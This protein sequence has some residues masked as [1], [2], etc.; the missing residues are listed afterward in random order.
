M[1][2]K[3]LRRGKDKFYPEGSYREHIAALAAYRAQ[4]A[5]V[6]VLIKCAFDPRTRLGPFAGPDYMMPPAGM[7]S[8]AAAFREAGFRR[9]RAA[10]GLWNPNLRPSRAR[11]AGRPI[12]VLALSAMQIHSHELYR[13]I[14][15]AHRLGDERPLIIAGGAKVI[16][17]PYH[18]FGLKRAGG[19]FVHP[20]EGHL[21]DLLSAD[22]AVHGREYEMVVVL[23]RLREQQRP[24]ESLRASFRRLAQDGALD[25]IPGLMFVRQTDNERGG[26]LVDTGRPRVMPTLDEMAHDPLLGLGCLERPH[27]RET[28]DARA[29]S[30]KEVGRHA[31]VV[32][33]EMTH[34]CPENCFY[35]PIP[36]EVHNTYRVK[37]PAK[38]VEEIRRV[39]EHTSVRVFFETS[40]NIGA[41]RHYLQELTAAL[42]AEMFQGKPLGD[43]IFIGTESTIKGLHKNLDLVPDLRRAG[44]RG[45]WFGIEDL[46]E[47]LVEKGQGPAATEAVFTALYDHGIAANPMFI[48]HAGQ[49]WSVKGRKLPLAL[50]ALAWLYDRKIEPTIDTSGELRFGLAETGE[51]MDRNH[52]TSRQFTYITPSIGTEGYDLDF[53]QGRVIERVGAQPVDDYLFDGNHTVQGS[54]EED[55][56][57]KQLEL[58]AAYWHAYRPGK[59]VALTAR[60]LAH[61]VDGRPRE[62]DWMD[63]LYGL[64]GMKG[65][66]ITS[67][68][69][70]GWAAR[71]A[72]LTPTYEAQ[73]PGPHLPT[74]GLQDPSELYARKSGLPPALAALLIPVQE[75]AAAPEWEREPVPGAVR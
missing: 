28:L 71:L 19:R 23:R 53:I 29:L 49:P 5:E 54:P 2:E 7:R 58:A 41:L 64:Y 61:R 48:H 14:E 34:G 10:F 40:D 60:L 67:K 55:L 20:T 1:A 70:Y 73:K 4:N 56:F 9:T 8:V 27:K 39:V 16:Y 72:R 66:A 3:L 37:S 45:I 31:T 24:G 46:N 57:V 62:R 65:Y 38:V 51:F 35:C 18:V 42:K 32:S 44:F 69:A 13:D 17:E 26:A 25:D 63:L 21:D 33:I 30:L 22:L 15:D 50:R 68:N 74:V 11:I 12:E 75:R 6:P 52:A 36:E 47:K 59:V 43:Q